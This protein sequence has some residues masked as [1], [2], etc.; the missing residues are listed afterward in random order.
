MTAIHFIKYYAYSL[1]N[2]QSFRNIHLSR[3][4][5][6]PQMSLDATNWHVKF[7]TFWG[8][9]PKSPYERGGDT[10]SCTLPPAAR[11]YGAHAGLRPA[12]QVLYFQPGKNTATSEVV[13]HPIELCTEPKAL[14]SETYV[15]LYI[16]LLTFLISRELLS[17]L[18]SSMNFPGLVNFSISSCL[19][20]ATCNREDSLICDHWWV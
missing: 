2:T 15:S 1:D 19:V 6:W 12:W 4:M 7:Q 10:T 18:K 14:Q 13:L 8:E 5:K 9:T 20:A 17:G 11:T 16:R 3:T